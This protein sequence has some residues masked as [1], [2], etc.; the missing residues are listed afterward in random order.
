MNR[1]GFL[2]TV[3]R[4]RLPK[5][6][7]TKYFHKEQTSN[8]D[9]HARVARFNHP[10]TAVKTVECCKPGTTEKSS[11]TKVHVSFQSTSSTNIQGVDSLNAVSR[12]VQKKDRGR[13]KHKRSWVIESNHARFF[14]LKQHGR[15]DTIDGQA[16]CCNLSLGNIVGFRQNFNLMP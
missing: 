15:V 7:P 4:G 2:S 9:N 6:I 16:A 5:G 14:Y 3:Q 11:Y 8:A 12:F 10:I 1:F 13:G